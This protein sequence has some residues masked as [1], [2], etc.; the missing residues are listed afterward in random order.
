MTL[1]LPIRPSMVTGGAMPGVVTWRCT[2][3]E[4]DTAATT[5]ARADVDATHLATATP[6]YTIETSVC[7]HMRTVSPV[8]RCHVADFDADASSLAGASGTAA[9]TY[10]DTP[11]VKASLTALAASLPSDYP[12]NMF[13]V[14]REG[15]KLEAMRKKDGARSLK[16]ATAM[17]DLVKSPTPL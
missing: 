13:M 2:R 12:I 4:H 9:V 7:F 8:C 5:H 15:K 16:D 11:N 1:R 14:E 6:D 10:A 17:S 3:G